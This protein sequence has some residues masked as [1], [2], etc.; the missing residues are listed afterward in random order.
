MKRILEL[1]LIAGVA[2]GPMLL[3]AT[4]PTPSPREALKPLGH[5]I[6][7]WRGTG[8][9]SA[10]AGGKQDFWSETI[11]WEWQF[12]GKDAWLKVAFEK[13]K[14]FTGG[15][16]H[17][18]PEKDE[19]ALT[20]LTTGKETQTF[21]G[22]LKDK[23]LTLQRE[24]G[25]EI[26]RMV[27]NFLHPGERYLY[28]YEVKP[29]GKA[30]FARK[31]QVGATNDAIQ[32]AGGDGKP[33]CVVSGGLGTIAVTYQGKTY[34]VCCSGCRTEFNEDPAKYVAEFEARQAKKK[35]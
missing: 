1:V 3:A 19:F 12:K 31:Y 21:T 27:F 7:T 34:Y 5:L 22:P 8:T 28:H 17:Y 13:S 30:L 18:L 6:G 11:A 16:L 33:E 32:F 26:H 29:V 20:L 4:Q 24:Q 14:N 9:A 2:A 25:G 35:K 10:T 15:E 23:K